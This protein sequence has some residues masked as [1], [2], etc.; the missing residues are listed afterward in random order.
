MKKLILPTILIVFLPVLGLAQNPVRYHFFSGDTLDGFD[1]TRVY[2]DM[3]SFSQSH[4]LSPVEQTHYM[5]AKEKTFVNNKY[6]LA[7][8]KHQS[9]THRTVHSNPSLFATCNNLDF[10]TGDYTGWTGAYG[11]NGNSSGPISVLS[12]TISSLGLNSPEGSCSYHTIVTGAIGTDP[13]GLFPQLDPGGGS[14]AERL[15]GEAI[16]QYGGND[17]TG[18][19]FCSGGAY[20]GTNLCSGAE[21]IEQTFPVTSAN[22]MFSYSYAV[23]LHDGGHTTGEQPYFRVEVL[24]QSGNPLPCLQYYQEC[25]N[26][27]PP[28][29]YSTSALNG[30]VFYIG[31][32]HNTL[33][34]KPYLGTNVTVRFTAAGCIYGGHFGYAYIDATCGPLQLIATTPPSCPPAAP[35][36][37]FTAPN[38]GLSYSWAKVP[39]GAGIV[40]SATGQSVTINQNGTYEVTVTTGGGCSYTMDT[41][42]SFP[43]NPSLVIASSNVSC[44]GGSNGTASVTASLGTTPYTYVWAPSGGTGATASGLPVGTYTVTVTTA[45][46]CSATAT[47]TITQPILLTS[48]N[49]QTNVSCHGGANGTATVNPSGGTP[50]YTYLWAPS[51]GTGAT[52]SGLAAGN[53]TCTITDSKGCITSSVVTITQPTASSS[54]TTQTNVSCHGGTNG[55]ASV[56]IFGG[57]PAYTYAWTPT[58]GTGASASGLSAGTYTCTVT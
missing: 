11:Y 51:G 34:L 24:D 49:S 12:P 16:N 52:A 37:T 8:P 26:G 10:E 23:V 31:W 19:Y 50:G 57:T 3:L 22:A 40:G 20:D 2:T 27:T 25:N 33:N 47:A 42:I 7:P 14:Y 35:S 29:G 53:Y 1:L 21:Y 39:P 55:T 36:A 30:S 38:G 32:Q 43:V 44:N 9:I 58:G 18:T 17:Y 48:T 46:G 4:H 15:G 28:P 13:Y 5:F 6:H 56:A 45:S 41:V 54:I